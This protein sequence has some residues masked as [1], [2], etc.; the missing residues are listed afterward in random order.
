[1]ILCRRRTQPQKK[2]S[3]ELLATPVFTHHID[4]HR[5]AVAI[6]ADGSVLRYLP[7]Q[8]RDVIAAMPKTVAEFLVGAV[9][10]V[11]VRLRSRTQ[12]VRPRPTVLPTVNR[13]VVRLD[14]R[15]CSRTI[16]QIG[17]V[18]TGGRS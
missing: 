16:V 6:G 2:A 18:G 15:S 7:R 14:Q 9:L 17:L 4:R 13:V 8:H 11:P 12:S 1:I 5:N 3:G 10:R